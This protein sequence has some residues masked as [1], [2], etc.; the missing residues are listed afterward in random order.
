MDNLRF[1]LLAAAAFVMAFAGIGWAA[2]GFPVLSVTQALPDARIPAFADSVEKGR[3]EAFVH[4]HTAQGDGNAEREP[5]R[6]ALA[7]AATAFALSPC[8]PTM[9]RNLVAALSA[10]AKA[11][12]DM[13]GCSFAL[14]GYDDRKIDAAAAAFST[15]ADKR[16][17]DAVASAFEKGGIAIEDFP[18]AIRLRVATIANDRGSPVSSCAAGTRA[19]KT[20]PERTLR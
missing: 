8:D 16:V 2:R 13:A 9:K 17:R 15:A 10:Y 1:G 7:Q 12:S 6:L 20:A 14:C 19:D 4:A 11:W 3:R 18:A 5:L